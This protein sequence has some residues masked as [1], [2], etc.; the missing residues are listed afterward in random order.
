MEVAEGVPKALPFSQILFPPFL[1]S[2]S[3]PGLRLLSDWFS[4]IFPAPRAAQAQ[5]YPAKA[6]QGAATFL[7]LLCYGNGNW[8]L[9]MAPR[10]GFGWE[11]MNELEG[12][13]F[14]CSH[15]LCRES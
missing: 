5:L 4:W 11:F 6:A 7:P 2:A 13:K 3:S 15:A 8:A 14:Q 9:L 12:D 10:S 1:V